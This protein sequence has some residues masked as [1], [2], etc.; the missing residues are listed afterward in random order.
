M[1][2]RTLASMISTTNDYSILKWPALLNSVL[3][4][5][6]ALLLLLCFSSQSW[7]MYRS[8]SVG[9]NE[10]AANFTWDT[11]SASGI[12]KFGLWSL[13]IDGYNNLTMQCVTWIR[14]TRPEYFGVIN[15]LITCGAFLTNLAIFP[16]W[17]L[18]ILILYNVKNTFIRYIVVFL[19]ILFC[20][21][22]AVACLSICSMIFV[23]LTKYYA[24]GKFLINSTYVLFKNGPGIFY[25]RA[26][27]FY[28][29]IYM[30]LL[31]SQSIDICFFS[32]HHIS[33]MFSNSSCIIDL[34]KIY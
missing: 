29:Y 11:A 25:L 26:G 3:I 7:F 17:A 27:K 13:C 30:F 9:A 8:F 21:I 28:I 20:L 10:T 1:K 4:T 15:I 24:P 18:T 33:N 19:W 14:E 16:S 12:N 32:Y 23:T 22:I 31:Y 5:I 34:A 2:F 6:L